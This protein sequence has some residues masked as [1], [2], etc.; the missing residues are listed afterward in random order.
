MAP[1]AAPRAQVVDLMEALK[2]SLAKRKP[3][4]KVTPRRAEPARA[5]PIR[6]ARRAQGKK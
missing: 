6:A 3:P 1:P 2:E 4:A 5:E